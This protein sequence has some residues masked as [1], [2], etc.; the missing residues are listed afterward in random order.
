MRD[1][2]LGHVLQLVRSLSFEV[3]YLRTHPPTSGATH[4]L[5]RANYRPLPSLPRC[6]QPHLFTGGRIR[7]IRMYALSCSPPVWSADLSSSPVVAIAVAVAVG[8]A[9]GGIG[10]S[11]GV[12][13]SMR[14]AGVLEPPL[15]LILVM[16]MAAVVVMEMV[17]VMEARL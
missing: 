12:Q 9:V 4:P 3:G 13:G 16:V 2:A 14:R 17:V 7:C 15:S 5:R 10:V 6:G 8:I 11:V 1:S